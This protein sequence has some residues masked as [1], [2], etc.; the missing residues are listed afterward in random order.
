M[1]TIEDGGLWVNDVIW[2]APTTN[3]AVAAAAMAIGILT[4]FTVRSFKWQALSLLAP[5]II[6]SG[7]GGPT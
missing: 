7:P 4:I 3:A 5:P 1:P 2:K 6:A